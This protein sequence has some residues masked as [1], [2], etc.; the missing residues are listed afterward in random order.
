MSKLNYLTKEQVQTFLE[1]G[2][3]FIKSDDMWTPDEKKTLID[4]VN[5][6]DNWP[7]QKGK[8]MK[9]FEKNLLLE[10]K[11][12]SSLANVTTNTNLMTTNSAATDASRASRLLSRIENF[13]QYNEGMN[14]IVNGP[15]LLGMCSQLFNE[16]AVLYKE[17]INYK[18]PG[19]SGFAPHQ[20]ISAGWW[21]YGQT[22]HISTL[23]T[24]DQ[25][26]LENGCL[27]VVYNKH[28]DGKLAADWKEIPTEVVEKLKFVPIQT[29]PGDIVF[30]DSY[31]PH[32]SGPNLTQKP[33]RVLYATYSKFAEGDWRDKYY[34]D[35]RKSYPPD[36]EREDG[37]SYQYKI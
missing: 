10:N 37:K 33:R 5:L 21:M 25:A 7:E 22:L 20:D 19:G 15:K 2:I 18:L 24:I 31:V 12:A 6:M 9:Y 1:T 26:T 29:K 3:L 32:R 34:A 8:W 27:E 36:I 14:A 17:K 30:F 4:S 35:K 28:K 13:A 23:V 11:D 16:R